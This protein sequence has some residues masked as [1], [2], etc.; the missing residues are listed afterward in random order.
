MNE[1]AKASFIVGGGS[2]IYVLSSFG[3]D[4]FLY[5]VSEKKTEHA[6]L[7]YEFTEMIKHNVLYDQH[8]KQ[9]NE[10]VLRLCDFIW[11]VK[12]LKQNKLKVLYTL[13]FIPSL[14]AL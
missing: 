6:S 10:L 13:I 11:F 1:N 2:N 3:I 5:R 7:N 12:H 4:C 9:V 8:S 14:L